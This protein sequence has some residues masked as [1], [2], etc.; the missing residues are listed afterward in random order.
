M[1]QSCGTLTLLKVVTPLLEID[2]NP[3]RLPR[4]IDLPLDADIAQAN[5][6]LAGVTSSDDLKGIEV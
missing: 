6:Y 3:V 4:H 5:E 1:D 2:I